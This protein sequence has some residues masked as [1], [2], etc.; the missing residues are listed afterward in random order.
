[1]VCIAQA[2]VH[3]YRKRVVQRLGIPIFSFM[4]FQNVL[5]T[6]YVRIACAELANHG[7]GC[8]RRSRNWSAL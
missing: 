2:T 4:R 5:R 8:L 6:S 1:M 7:I 3:Q